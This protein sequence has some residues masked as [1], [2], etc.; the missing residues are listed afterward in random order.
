MSQGVGAFGS[1][2][3]IILIKKAKPKP[4]SYMT[5]FAHRIPKVRLALLWKKRNKKH[6]WQLTSHRKY[7][8]QTTTKYTFWIGE[9]LPFG[10]FSFRNPDIC[11]GSQF[12]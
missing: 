10:L 1:E 12:S 2:V 5:L 6:K 4:S 3:D 9:F 11:S 8:S 7:S